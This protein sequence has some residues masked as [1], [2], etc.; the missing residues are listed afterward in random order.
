MTQTWLDCYCTRWRELYTPSPQS[1]TYMTGWSY[2]TLHWTPFSTIQALPTAPDE[3]CY[4]Q[5]VHFKILEE[6]LLLQYRWTPILFPL[7][8]SSIHDP[9]C[10]P[11]TSP[12]GRAAWSCT[13]SCH[14]QFISLS[15]T[16][17]QFSFLDRTQDLDLPI[18]ISNISPLPHYDFL[19]WTELRSRLPIYISDVSSFG[20]QSLLMIL[21]FIVLLL[22]QTFYLW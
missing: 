12:Q 6:S 21:L 15:I 17:S 9:I 11:Q 22:F 19:S 3:S 13:R 4:L 20:R 10:D 1:T 8:L 14:G 7:S 5:W 2:L 16:L 18:Y